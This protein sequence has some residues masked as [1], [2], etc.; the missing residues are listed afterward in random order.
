MRTHPTTWATD[1]PCP[2][3]CDTELTLT[4]NGTAALRAECPICGHAETWET[5]HPQPAGDR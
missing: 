4:D 2:N 1:E 3:G 5:S